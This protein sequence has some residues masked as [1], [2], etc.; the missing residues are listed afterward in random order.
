MSIG[1]HRQWYVYPNSP[2]TIRL[3]DGPNELISQSV[4]FSSLAFFRYD[5]L[6]DACIKCFLY[7]KNEMEGVE[8]IVS[9]GRF[10][11]EVVNRIEEM[12]NVLNEC[13]HDGLNL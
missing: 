4:C 9:G 11:R 7:Q 3:R 5:V 6:P 2:H 12:G 8:K 13:K 1:S 10:L